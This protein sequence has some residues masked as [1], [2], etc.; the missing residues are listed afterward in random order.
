MSVKHRFV[1][2][3]PLLL[4][5]LLACLIFSK[6]RAATKASACNALTGDSKL[7]FASAGSRQ[8][9]P[10]IAAAKKKKSYGDKMCRIWL[11]KQS[12]VTSG[13]PR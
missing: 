11:Q 3:L 10:E 4:Y 8:T 7:V 6:I 12:L 5:F 9:R 2:I 13:P 1:R